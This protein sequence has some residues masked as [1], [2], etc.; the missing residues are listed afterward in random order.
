MEYYGY[1]DYFLGTNI[2]QAELDDKTLRE[3]IKLSQEGDMEARNIVIENNIRLVLYLLNYYYPNIDID[4][5]EI[6]SIALEALIMCIDNFDYK[7][8]TSF[9][10]S[11]KV[12]LCNK[13]TNYRKSV[14]RKR[15]KYSFVDLEDMENI[16]SIPEYIDSSITRYELCSEIGNYISNLP[17][18][19]RDMLC[20]YYGIN[21]DRCTFREIGNIYNLSETRIQQ[22]VKEEVGKLSRR[23]YR[24][25]YIEKCICRK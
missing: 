12:Y 5:R 2:P 25:G 13:V 1:G 21:K 15:K 11:L 3:Y 17:D 6:V 24:E 8:H 9:S 20:L 22:I 18:N 4:K 10:N 16:L 23:L 14:Y 19:R 7:N